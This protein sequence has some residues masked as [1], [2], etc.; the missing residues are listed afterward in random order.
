MVLFRAKNKA[1]DWGVI[2][3]LNVVQLQATD[4]EE[5]LNTLDGL[6]DML[7]ECEPGNALRR[8]VLKLFKVAQ[9]VLELK[10]EDSKQMEK[11]LASSEMELTEAR[12][13]LASGADAALRQ[14]LGDL[15]RQL[16]R[17]E[18]E[19]QQ[20]EEVIADERRRADQLQHELEEAQLRTLAAE[21]ALEA[22]RTDMEDYR[23]HIDLQRSALTE[24]G[25]VPPMDL[26]EEL[27]EKSRQ[28]HVYVQRLETAHSK[29]TQLEAEVAAMTKGMEE[30][31]QNLDAANQKIED[32]Q[33][34]LFDMDRQ[35]EMLQQ[36]KRVLNSKVE[37][38]MDQAEAKVR[39]D[40]EIMASV[41][42][43]IEQWK[44]LLG[45]KDAELAAAMQVV[46]SL[47]NELEMGSVQRQA[48]LEDQVILRDREIQQLK[49]QL[50]AAAQDLETR[51][52]NS[53]TS[54]NVASV[55]ALQQKLEKAQQDAR[56]AQQ[57]LTNK[58]KELFDTLKRMQEY[59]TGV[60]GLHDA[61]KEIKTYKAQVGLRDKDIAKLT[62]DVNAA[63]QHTGQ[64]LDENEELRRRLG[65]PASADVDLAD[66]RRQRQVELEQ[67]R[68]VNRTLSKDVERLEAERL[69]L[70]QRLL[71]QAMARGERAVE[72]GLTTDDLALWENHADR[73][74]AAPGSAAAKDMVPVQVYSEVRRENDALKR[75]NQSLQQDVERLRQQLEQ[76]GS[77]AEQQRRQSQD[78]DR[79]R[80]QLQAALHSVH[81]KIA[82]AG[83]KTG[84]VDVNAI[85][86]IMAGA[87]AGLSGPADAGGM[88]SDA[89][90]V[91]SHSAS[92]LQNEVS[93][94][95]GANDELRGALS[96][97]QQQA[98]QAQQEVQRRTVL[99]EAQGKELESLRAAQIATS[100]LQP[101]K[102]PLTMNASSADVIA[103]LNE[104]LVLVLH[105]LKEKQ[106]VL[107]QTE[108][109][110]QELK[111]KYAV[112]VQ[113]QGL[114]YQDFDKAQKQ[115][116]AEKE[117]VMQQMNILEGELEKAKV[118][119][120]EL[121]RQTDLISGDPDT[122]KAKSADLVRKIAV[123][124]V[125]EKALIRR[126]TLISSREETLVR[127][128]NK[129]KADMVEMEAVVQQ[130]IAYLE[131]HKEAS[132]F[133]IEALEKKLADSVDKKDVD[134][135]TRR[136]QL[137][138]SKYR[139]VLE[140]ENSALTQ[141]MSVET[142]KHE[143]QQLQNEQPL[144]RKQ[145]EMAYERAAKAEE[146]LQTSYQASGLD[147]D[148]TLQRMQTVEM[149][150]LNEKQRAD[151]LQLQ[152]EQNKDLVQRLQQRN[153]ELERKF[154]DLTEAHLTAQETEKELK[155]VLAGCV[156]QAQHD[157]CRKQLDA[158]QQKEAELTAEVAR[159]KDVAKVA[160]Q[161]V[162]SNAHNRRM[163]T[164]ELAAVRQQLVSQQMHDDTQTA[165]GKLQHQLLASQ[166]SEAES[167]RKI[168][169]LKKHNM[170]L[171]AALLGLERRVDQRNDALH[172][173]RAEAKSKA[174]YLRRNLQ[175]LRLQ[176]SGA[177]TLEQQESH[178]EALRA[179]RARKQELEQQVQAVT[180]ERFA[181]EDRLAELQLQH[182]SLQE[183]LS[184]LRS[185]SGAEKTVQWHSKLEETRLNELRV[186]RELVR[187]KE[188]ERHLQSI[189]DENEKYM[190]DMEQ[191]SV[192]F[193]K[194]F[195]EKMMQW[196][197]RETDLEKA[198]EELE[199]DKER[200]Y[201]AATRAEAMVRQDDIMPDPSQP[202]AHQLADALERLQ[203]LAALVKRQAKDAQ[204]A[205]NQHEALQIEKRALEGEMMVK[206]KE[207]TEARIQ[208][209]DAGLGLDPRASVSV[210]QSDYAQSHA[211][212]VAHETIAGLNK[213]IEHK[214][215]ALRSMRSQLAETHE[216]LF[217]ERQQHS[218]EIENLR[219]QLG[220]QVGE[221][222]RS[223]VSEAGNLPRHS[224]Q[225]IESMMQRITELE[226]N[227]EE[228]HQEIVNLSQKLR[229]AHEKNTALRHEYE[230]KLSAVN[231]KLKEARRTYETAV[232]TIKTESAAE[233]ARQQD[234]MAE[235]MREREAA[236]PS[237]HTQTQTEVR[238]TPTPVAPE[239]QKQRMATATTNTSIDATLPRGQEEQLQQLQ[240][241][242]RQRDQELRTKDHQLGQ[243]RSAVE[244]L[245]AELVEASAQAVVA[246]QQADH[247]DDEIKRELNRKLEDC[248]S[249]ISQLQARIKEMEHAN[250]SKGTESARQQSQLHEE[251]QRKSEQLRKYEADLS[252]IRQDKRRL[253]EEVKTLT[254]DLEMEKASTK[255]LMKRVRILESRRVSQGA[256]P[257]ERDPGPAVITETQRWELDKKL[258][259]KAEVLKGKLE[260]SEQELAATQQQVE[261]LKA[262]VT[263]LDR[264]K[265]SLQSKLQS[266]SKA[267]DQGETSDLTAMYMKT[268]E[269][270]RAQLQA[271][272]EEASRFKRELRV[273][274]AQQIHELKTNNQR[275]RQM[276]QEKGHDSV[277][278]LG[279]M[280][281]RADLEALQDKE[282]ALGRR[283][284]ESE[285]QN[286]ELQFQLEDRG[287]EVSRLRSQLE[288]RTQI[289][290]KLDKQLKSAGAGA[291]IGGA[292]GQDVR[293]LQDELQQYQQGS[294]PKAKY[295]EVLRELKRIKEAQD[296]PA[297]HKADP[298]QAKVAAD[299]ERVKVLM[300]KEKETSETLRRRVAELERE[301]K[302]QKKSPSQQL[303]EELAE[304][305][306]KLKEMHAMLVASET[307]EQDLKNRLQQQRTQ[308]SVAEQKLVAE[309]EQLRKELAAFDPTFF[310]EIEDLKYNYGEALAQI[311]R[312][313]SELQTIARTYNIT[314][315]VTK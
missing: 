131:R 37:D 174:R 282:N 251:A 191:Q 69:Q 49:A 134:D 56:R 136:M 66:L 187:S 242:L 206:D 211:Q 285:K 168:E 256:V 286:M 291:G 89:V 58:D 115:W 13:K 29:N 128:N 31:V 172:N 203:G 280:V 302:A 94:L 225:S 249:T 275:L 153:A 237:A 198:L 252:K 120:E 83:G 245:R 243:M 92:R 196:E 315:S 112:L 19:L 44:Q 20:Q 163:L 17:R 273:D 132:T 87:D 305:D 90:L 307:A 33:Q 216:E 63:N 161:Q 39:S 102:L 226:G 149:R 314:T 167:V 175:A 261:S 64:L 177:L 231:S 283:L 294:V 47:K 258:Q 277:S 238:E 192:R 116:A 108:E 278:D 299:Y 179:A 1:V 123:L 207:L 95:K 97:A 268:E 204:D 200:A 5:D 52:T 152:N 59:E 290:A 32:L 72:L 214:D 292:P 143:I 236:F 234:A 43:T 157:A 255:E 202:V 180:K 304:K 142:L 22:A 274:A 289:A 71:D 223:V 76:S 176:Y 145:I 57:D 184:T 9:L 18:L 21:Q 229:A 297:D 6:Y 137:L 239:R 3:N 182:T 121:R 140:K 164:Q 269:Q 41:N 185:G 262:T 101:L 160:V 284:L 312:Y 10:G 232:E 155:D 61:V 296:Q 146:M 85:E 4:K 107:M 86:E 65:L 218:L 190:K 53:N 257:T 205:A 215:Q 139:S 127:E 199:G 25:G 295:M 212:K 293:R 14:E 124:R 217:K 110:M 99:C 189:I 260:R 118:Y 133:K 119:E 96:A 219:K 230:D 98:R 16:Q 162:D 308:S 106:S 50:Q 77:H 244:Q 117:Q 240:Q 67:L 45:E 270:L 303:Q 70:K 266:V 2:R 129:L 40:D 75:S 221:A 279:A 178:T 181:V 93:R 68:A 247:A 306:R 23:K 309:N 246:Q 156:T 259:K 113:Q 104:H 276:L 201:R 144:L 253:A 141:H 195:E 147:D 7:I 188:R 46:A 173:A 126:H 222:A 30:A 148:S 210:S 263:R 171:E 151:L 73:R 248:Q 88:A 165:Q 114:V 82:A 233:I 227:V 60:Y 12:R 8:D 186:K 228:Q 271:A 55:A 194:E 15:Q 36:E 109:D 166:L 301:I 11:E 130:R 150:A 135:L 34:S 78:T 158:L 311:S 54:A 24:G 138:A 193:A 213:M 74:V 197:Q 100:A 111:Q 209:A 38:L 264:E 288:Q 79:Q 250:S 105:D 208:L 91:R 183:L 235:T 26:N 81:D 241:Q 154:Q 267:A 62:R 42:Q 265:R 281:P 169:L 35:N 272:Q 224:G 313:R 122:V 48:Q 80:R 287:L 254:G 298:A 159:L 51:A 103:S 84:D 220:K 300:R 27:R 28:L 125:N 310:E 170:E